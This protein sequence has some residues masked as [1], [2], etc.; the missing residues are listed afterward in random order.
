MGLG[1][2]SEM[3]SVRTKWLDTEVLSAIDSEES[4]AKQLV[5]LGAGYDDDTRGFRLIFCSGESEGDD[6]TVFEVD[7]PAVQEK[8]ISKLDWL[9]KNDANGK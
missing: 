3:I 6:C 9:S 8:K 7:Q 2:F 5:I 4:P 1:C